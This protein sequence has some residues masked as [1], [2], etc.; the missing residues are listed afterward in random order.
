M[1]NNK[2]EESGRQQSAENHYSHRGLY[3]IARL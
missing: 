1:Y 3:L 2:V